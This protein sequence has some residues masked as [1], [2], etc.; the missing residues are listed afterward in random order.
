MNGKYSVSRVAWVANEAG[1]SWDTGAMI[2]Y[3]AGKINQ[4]QVDGLSCPSAKSCVA[5]GQS[6]IKNS[7][8]LQIGRTDNFVATVTP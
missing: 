2:G 3:R 4:G 7:K 8:M 5:V 1:G 6:G